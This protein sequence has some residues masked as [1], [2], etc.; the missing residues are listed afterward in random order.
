MQNARCVRARTRLL[1]FALAAF[2]VTAAA[3]HSIGSVYDGT[4]RLT[5][6]GQV[7]DFQ[8]VNPHPFLVVA[9]TAGA[10]GEQRW[11]LEMDN[12]SELSG[13]GM[14]AQTFKAGD[15]VIVTGSLSRTQP[16]Q[17]YLWRLE[18][19]ADGFRY[20]QIGTRPYISSR[21]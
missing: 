19:P 21:P 18:R 8:F 9:A 11:R 1:G 13:I 20:E 14:T 6:E 3:H 7:T 4:K 10:E 12:R 16:Q 17:L 15:R 2:C 5:L